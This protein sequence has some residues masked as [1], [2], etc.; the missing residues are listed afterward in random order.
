MR[1]EF[2]KNE[3]DKIRKMVY[4]QAGYRCELCGESG[5]DQGYR[6]PVEC[7]EVWD[8]DFE[9]NTQSLIGFIA[10]CPRCHKVVHCS[11][12]EILFADG[13]I[14]KE[15]YA[16]IRNQFRKVNGLSEEYS[17]DDAIAK[18]ICFHRDKHCIDWT[19]NIDYANDFLEKIK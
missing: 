2:E 18:N 8:L 12:T 13:K 15:E 14:S 4:R 10:L 11:L 9:T 5:I 16:A 7:H 3:W 17:I 1:S 6:W 19:V